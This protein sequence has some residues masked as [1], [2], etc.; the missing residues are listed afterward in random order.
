MSGLL[1][2]DLKKFSVVPPNFREKDPR[3]LLYHFPSL[4]AVTYAKL[5]QIYSFNQ[6]L[7]V[8]ES[9][10]N[11]SGYIL[12]PARCMNWKRVKGHFERRVKVGKHNFYMMREYELTKFERR[13]LIN[14]IDE[15][16][17]VD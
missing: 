16:H 15:I 13:K 4:P 5:M 1:L 6:S 3:S 12:L 17:V 10:A 2:D 11:F 7:E 8:A 9:V 14:Y